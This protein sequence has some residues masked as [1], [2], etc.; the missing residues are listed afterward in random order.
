MAGIKHAFTSAKTDSPDTTLVRPT[1]WNADHVITGDVEF[2]GFNIKTTGDTFTITLDDN[3]DGIGT[4]PALTLGTTDPT[5]AGFG[6]TH[7]FDFGSNDEPMLLLQNSS[8]SSGGPSL[9]LYQNSASPAA[10]DLP[11]QIYVYG[12]DSAGNFQAWGDIFWSITDPTS[13]SE[14]STV[15]FDIQ[16]GGSNLIALTLGSSNFGGA[17]GPIFDVGSSNFASATIQGAS[18]ADGGPFLTLYHNSASPG[19]FDQVG[20]IN[21][22]GRDSAANNQKYGG[23]FCQPSNVT[24]GTETS[25]LKFPTYQSGS[26]VVSLALGTDSGIGGSTN[27]VTI[28]LGSAAGG[29][30]LIQNT[31]ATGIGI[32][33]YLYNNSASPAANDIASSII[34]IGK[35]SGGNAQEYARTQTY[36][37]DAT[38]GSEDGRMASFVYQG[39]SPL[40]MLR[41]EPNASVCNIGSTDFSFIYFSN[42]AAGNGGPVLALKQNSASPAAGDFLTV[43][44]ILG[45]DST[46]VETQYASIV[47]K[48]VDATNTIEAGQLQFTVTASG[49]DVGALTLGTTTLANAW[50][51]SSNFAG[52]GVDGSGAIEASNTSA[53]ATG[54]SVNFY[55]NSASPAANDVTGFLRFM[56]KDSAGNIQEYADIYH[57][58][59][60][61]TSTSEDGR[62]E[63]DTAVAGS[64]GNRLNIAGGLYHSS[65]VG[66]DKGNNTTNF[67][68]QYDDGT[69]LITCYV[70]EAARTGKVDL[71]YWDGLVG[72]GAAQGCRLVGKGVIGA[73]DAIHYGAHK[74]AAR[75]GT[76]YDPTTLAGQRKHMRDKQHLTPYQ[77]REN[78]SEATR[79]SLGSWIQRGVEMDELLFLYVCQLEDRLAAL[80]ATI[81]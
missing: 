30:C 6:L 33:L 24:A 5:G 68:N 50:P 38:S 79:P 52:S 43:I 1:N 65:A 22:Y 16:S 73:P 80:E 10:N 58:I 28:D 51:V 9:V 67:S 15:Y 12:K 81:H 20:G 64:V 44:K 36:I 47:G 39:G 41:L 78:F 54:P 23:V 37:I 17:F 60:D 56:G 46:A 53:G 57:I 19:A 61:A 69:L 49:S 48:I 45:N 77:N 29:N 27:V 74:F 3:N 26:E 14:D 2:S 18:A 4:L 8:A 66:T 42:D 40:E 71:A 55:Q 34:S 63:F 75:L 31:D 25:S 32:G 11:G 62:L 21:F 76:E 59:N 70:D 13:G 7:L 72:D 35:D